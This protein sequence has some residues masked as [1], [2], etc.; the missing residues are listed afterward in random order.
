MCRRTLSLTVEQRGQLKQTRDRD[1]RAYLRECAAALLKVADGHSARQVALHGL[2]KR[3]KPDTVYGWI[4]K[5]QRH[6]LCGLVHKPRG[7]RGFSPS[8][9]T[10]AG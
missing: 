9:G 5:Y 8:V 2:N 1:P 3:R 7:H 4:E 6:G 10:R